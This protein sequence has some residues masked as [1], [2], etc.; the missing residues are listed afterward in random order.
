MKFFHVFLLAR[1][2]AY[3]VY[4]Y[5]LTFGLQLSNKFHTSVF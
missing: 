5:R 1:I 4:A 3:I 2:A